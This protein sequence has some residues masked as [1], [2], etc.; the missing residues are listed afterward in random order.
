MV[1]PHRSCQIYHESG[2]LQSGPHGCET[3]SANSSLYLMEQNNVVQYKNKHTKHSEL[4][5][6]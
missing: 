6:E 3:L 5:H 1:G 2:V 4:M